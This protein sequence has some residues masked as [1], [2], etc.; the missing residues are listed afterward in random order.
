MVVH[1]LS[2]YL[3]RASPRTTGEEVDGLGRAGGGGG[4]GGG[5]P[6]AR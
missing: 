5:E 6:D 3:Y 2:S 1:G 4:G